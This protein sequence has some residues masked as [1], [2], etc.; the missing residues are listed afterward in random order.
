MTMLEELR[1]R[2][3]TGV[4]IEIDEQQW[5][6]LKGADG[7][8]V[9]VSDDGETTVSITTDTIIIMLLVPLAELVQPLHLV[10]SR[11]AQATAPLVDGE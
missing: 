11:M 4:Q 2:D 1:D 5:T 3:W 9:A 7:M 6:V 10:A 8:W